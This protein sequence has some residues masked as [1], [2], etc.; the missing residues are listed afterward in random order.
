MV[1]TKPKDH[2]ITTKTILVVE[3]PRRYSKCRLFTACMEDIFNGDC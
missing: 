2:T 3:T 1:N